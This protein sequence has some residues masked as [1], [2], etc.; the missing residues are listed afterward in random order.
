MGCDCEGFLSLVIS[1]S[2]NLGTVPL[3]FTLCIPPA[4]CE[5]CQKDE[6]QRVLPV[7]L[8]LLLLVVMLRRCQSPPL[9][10]LLLSVPSN[11]PHRGPTGLDKQ[12]DH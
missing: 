4:V 10:S 8:L 1:W 5:I 12:R 7:L 6:A 3:C 2:H 11:A 9:L